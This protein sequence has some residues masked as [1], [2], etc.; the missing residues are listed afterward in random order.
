ML[1]ERETYLR[2]SRS[3]RTRHEIAPNKR[4]SEVVEQAQ[5][6]C[7][8]VEEGQQVLTVLTP[9]HIDHLRHG[10][11]VRHGKALR[12]QVLAPVLEFLVIPSAFCLQL[13]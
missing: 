1:L 7:L 3:I 8:P 2:V 6:A 11:I 13:S 9:P 10:H 5:F 4:D 12:E